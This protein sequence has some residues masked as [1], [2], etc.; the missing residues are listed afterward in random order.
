MPA[1]LK[2]LRAAINIDISRNNKL[3]DHQSTMDK[4]AV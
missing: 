2:M 3:I 1:S 4:E